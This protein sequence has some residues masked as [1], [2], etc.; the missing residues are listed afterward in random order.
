M[1]PG[2]LP[3]RQQR[4]SRA[5][6]TTHHP[7]RDTRSADAGPTGVRHPLVDR[8]RIPPCGTASAAGWCRRVGGV[9]LAAVCGLGSGDG[10]V[11]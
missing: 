4:A 10:G 8:A 7:V 2:S 5:T 9:C 3:A 1:M 11:S 6:D